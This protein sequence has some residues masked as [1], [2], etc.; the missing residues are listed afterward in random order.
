MKT[1]TYEEWLATYKPLTDEQGEVRYFET[2]GKEFETVNLTPLQLIWTQ[3]DSEDED[4]SI[5]R[6]GLS[7]VNRIN[8]II[9]REP[10]NMSESIIVKED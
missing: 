2:Y 4:R 5:I 1:I 10:F 9:C 8:Y 7:F 3:L 6:S